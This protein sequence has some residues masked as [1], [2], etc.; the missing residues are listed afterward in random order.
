MKRR[1][2]IVLALTLPVLLS[3]QEQARKISFEVA[4]QSFV[5]SASVEKNAE[6]INLNISKKPPSGKSV[7]VE[8][9]VD[10][11]MQPNDYI[12]EI[13]V[14]PT[15]NPVCKAVEFHLTPMNGHAYLA[16]NIK[17]ATSQK[18]V[19]LVRNNKGQIYQ[20]SQEVHVALSGCA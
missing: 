18:V 19:I 2:F 17:L 6:I 10:Y 1:K 20:Q 11:P 13:A 3:A 14:L 12:T 5:G 15:Q 9:T 7:P 16:C 4:Y 8:V